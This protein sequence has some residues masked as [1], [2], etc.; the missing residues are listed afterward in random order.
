MARGIYN[1][2]KLTLNGATIDACDHNGGYAVISY[3]GAEFT[4]NSGI[5]KTSNENG[6]D[7]TP[8]NYDATPIRVEA[9]A[10]A[11][12]NGGTI[13]NVSN[14]TYALNNCAPSFSC[15]CIGGC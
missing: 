7:T 15:C 3:N 2:G 6:D 10:K 14:F 5:V 4:M 13:T 11:T 8:G 9:G 12:I 1:Y